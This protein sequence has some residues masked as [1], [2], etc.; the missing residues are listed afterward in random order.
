MK[1]RLSY[2][3][4]E[5]KEHQFIIEGRRYIFKR[6]SSLVVDSS[7]AGILQEKKDAFGNPLFL[8]TKKDDEVEEIPE[9]RV[10]SVVPPPEPKPE[11]ITK[12]TPPD[13]PKLPLSSKK[14]IP[15]ARKILDRK[16]Q[17]KLV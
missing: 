7:V 4:R 11:A 9:I 10:S 17:G 12:I 14:T 8:I 13:L 1:Y 16:K 2:L 6:G 15:P 3:G 5:T